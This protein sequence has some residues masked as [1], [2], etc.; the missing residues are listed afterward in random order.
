MVRSA[1]RWLK[2]KSGRLGVAIRAR[3]FVDATGDAD[4]C[5]RSG[6]RTQTG[7]ADGKCQPPTL[8]FRI[9]GID[10]AKVKSAGTHL[11]ASFSAN[12]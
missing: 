11:S 10:T 6:A 8:C 2:T 1:P 9:G 4:L 5:L 12:F 7:G 3:V